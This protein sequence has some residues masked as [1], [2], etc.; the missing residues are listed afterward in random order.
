MTRFLRLMLC[1]ALAGTALAAQARAA[2]DFFTD[3]PVDAFNLLSRITRQDMIDYYNA[4]LTTGSDNIFG[5]K[6]RI[7]R[8]SDNSVDFL[9]SKHSTATLAVLPAGS[10]TVIAI[11]ETVKTPTPD[12]S[13]A[14]FRASDWSRIP[15]ALPT[16]RDFLT[17]EGRKARLSAADFPDMNFYTVE[18]N[19]DTSVFTFRERTAEHYALPEGN[20][21][22]YAVL[23][24]L[25]PQISRILK[26]SRLVEPD[27]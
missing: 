13:I 12:S 17:P 18:F 19:P 6:A 8:A 2:L 23:Q 26:G 11:I 7:L 24:Y 10:D 5:G 9:V 21:P 14:F 4:G 20:P 3:M 25:M 27:K 1:V 16:M 22:E 15:V